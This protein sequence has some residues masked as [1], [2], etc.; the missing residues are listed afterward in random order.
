MAMKTS[1]FRE[2]QLGLSLS[3][4]GGGDEGHKMFLEQRRD[5][6]TKAKRQKRR[7]AR[8]TRKE[9]D[10]LDEEKV[11]YTSRYVFMHRI[12]ATVSKVQLG[13]I[14]CLAGLNVYTLS[15]DQTITTL[16]SFANE[17]VPIAALTGWA[18]AIFFMTKY[19]NSRHVE[20]LKY[21]EKNNIVTIGLSSM[22]PSPVLVP[23]DV[24]N[25]ILPSSIENQE[26]IKKGVE[27]FVTGHLA[28]ANNNSHM[29]YSLQGK[30]VAKVFDEDAFRQIHNISK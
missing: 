21:N 10:I 4:F 25:V 19:L 23:V 29:S 1:I 18:G 15:N 8:R 16:G 27:I 6:R 24:K 26:E 3:I 5:V 7:Q 11:I 17:C 30:A 9:E 20:S 22:S 13:G 14:L 2:N 12:Y 28:N